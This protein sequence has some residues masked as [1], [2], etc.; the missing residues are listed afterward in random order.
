MA[1]VEFLV[2]H[3]GLTEAGKVLSAVGGFDAAQLMEDIGA[4]LE[5]SS[6]RRISETKAGPDGTPWKA[7]S[8]EYAKTR[9]VQHSLLVGEGE[10]LDSIQS[11]SDGHEARVGTPLIY[12]AI[13]QG[14]GAE[15]GKP[16][17]PE[18]PYLGMSAEDERDIDD[19]VREALSELTRKGR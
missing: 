18:R 16:G 1:G 15:V 12:G 4:V 14:G 7:W 10:L 9:G 13:H 8:P 5:S 19:L 3:H 2:E 6:R 11:Y 17:L